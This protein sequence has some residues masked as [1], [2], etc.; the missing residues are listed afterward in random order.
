MKQ[1][2]S[3]STTKECW[4]LKTVKK[5]IKK[6]KIQKVILPLPKQ[7]NQWGLTWNNKIN[8]YLEEIYKLTP[9]D[10]IKIKSYKLVRSR[11]HIMSW[12]IKLLEG[13]SQRMLTSLMVNSLR[14]LLFMIRFSLLRLLS[15]KVLT[16]A[17]IPLIFSQN[18]I[19]LHRPIIISH[20]LKISLI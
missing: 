1:T 11:N 14:Y 5:C 18:K 4:I 2:K 8:K 6:V 3:I 15:N 12:I 19:S 20:Q 17:R 10:F 16:K 9:Q 13:I 7:I